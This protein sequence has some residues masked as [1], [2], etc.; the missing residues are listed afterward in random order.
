MQ[1]MAIVRAEREES[2]EFLRLFKQVFRSINQMYNSNPRRWRN[3]VCLRRDWVYHR[4]RHEDRNAILDFA[5]HEVLG[6]PQRQE[7]DE[8][9]VTYADLVRINE[10]RRL[11]LKLG[12]SKWG[13]AGRFDDA[14]AAINDIDSLDR[15]FDKVSRSSSWAE[16]FSDESE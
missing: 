15:I 5:R 3:L 10:I 6:S 8:M 12:T 14:I 13:P 1:A 11:I 2:D 9:I 16:L 7:V 4:R